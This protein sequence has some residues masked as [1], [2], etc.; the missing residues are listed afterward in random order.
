MSTDL[1]KLSIE[2][3]HAL[4]EDLDAQRLALRDKAKAAKAVLAD[5][6]LVEAG[7]LKLL[8]MTAG[9]RAALRKA[10]T[11]DANAVDVPVTG[12]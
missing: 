3:L 4:L 6:Q 10:L 2:Q 7:A 5:R 1:S 8:K 9:E 11:A 12:A